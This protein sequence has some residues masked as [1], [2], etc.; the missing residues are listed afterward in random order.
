[1]DVALFAA[2]VSLSVYL[3]KCV[4]S[5]QTSVEQ[6]SMAVA[7]G[8]SLGLF[9]LSLLEA[10]PGYW[11]MILSSSSPGNDNDNMHDNEEHEGWTT[12]TGTG[13]LP[14]SRAYWILLWMLSLVI[15]VAFPC[16]AGAAIAET[17]GHF[18]QST[19]DRDDQKYPLF[20]SYWRACPWWIRFL[21]SLVKIV[22]K[23]LWKICNAFFRSLRWSS[24]ESSSVLAMTVNDE[25]SQSQSLSRQSAS[26]DTELRGLVSSPKNNNNANNTHSNNNRFLMSA[27]SICGIS[28]VLV[29]VSSL[30]PIVVQTSSGKNALS[31][32]VSWL[33][34]I[35]LMISSLMNGFGSVSMPYS[36]LAGLYLKPVHPEVI[37]KLEAEL[38]SVREAMSNKRATLRET[39]VAIKQQHSSTNNSNLNNNTNNTTSKIRSFADL[40][41]ELG[42]RKQVLQTEIDFLEVLCKDM[43]EDIDELRYSQSVAA[44][45]RTPMGKLRSYVGL[46]FSVLLLVRLLS[47]GMS[48]WKSYTMDTSRHKVAHGDIVTTVLLWLTGHDLVSLKK[49]TMLSQVVSLGLTALL[50]FTQ[51]RTFLRTVAAVHRQLTR[52]YQKCY[53]GTSICSKGS[54]SSNSSSSSRKGSD[55]LSDERNLHGTSELFSSSGIYSQIVAGATGCYFLSCIVLIKM[56]LPEEFCGGFSTAMG[57][58]DVFTIHTSVVNTVF[59][60]SAGVTATVQAMLFGIQRQHN[61]RHTS[62]TTTSSSSP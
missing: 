3:P 51:I 18:F 54:S 55:A 11:L 37:T 24:K 19:T 23:N 56:M 7:I 6:S 47:A 22:V 59:A 58:M 28:A 46:V 4:F 29:L 8:L 25:E 35:G 12:T 42:N 43:E 48:I 17:F 2:S 21:G 9:S 5:L 33:C 34:A 10:T 32:I 52:F 16:L 50:S 53:C 57:G 62:S 36:C 60:C 44:A 14:I 30:G 26:G 13:L 20:D 15:L 41:D 31:V 61:F 1:M 38:Q 49:H 45:A 40:G 39:T 27:G